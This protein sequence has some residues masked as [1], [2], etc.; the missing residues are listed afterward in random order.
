MSMRY[1]LIPVLF[2]AILSAPTPANAATCESL[3][4]VKLPDTT[5]TLVQTASYK[6]TGSIADAANFT[7]K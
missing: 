4:G 6:G 1:T 7:C 5:I 2:A 3:A